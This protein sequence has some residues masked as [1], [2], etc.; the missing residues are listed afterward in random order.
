MFDITIEQAFIVVIVLWVIFGVIT[1]KKS[2][3]M[4][5]E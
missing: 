4:G 2:D 3:G 1:Y 5:I